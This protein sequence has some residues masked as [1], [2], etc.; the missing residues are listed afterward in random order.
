MALR[1]P[2]AS[3][4]RYSP[5]YFLAALGAGGLTANFFVWLLFWVPHPERPV[6]VF[7]DIFGAW[8]SASTS[9]RLAIGVAV[10]GIILFALTHLILLVWN[11]L[12]YRRYR[13]TEAAR[14]LR[15]G[16]LET[17][18]L[19]LPL[20]VAMAINVGFVLGM[21]FVPGLWSVVEYLFP[22][23]MIAFL[24]VGFWAL[25]LLGDFYGRVLTKGGFDCTRNNSFAQMLPAFALAMVGVGLAAPAAM[26]HT[27]WVAGLSYL[28]SSFF[29]VAAL[30]LGTGK[31]VLGMRAMMESGANPES[32]PTLWL[33]VPIITVL[34]IT[35]LRQDHGA[36]VHLGAHTLP[37]ERFDL[38]VLLFSA[39]IAYLLLGAVVLRRHGYFRRFV[40]GREASSGSWTLIC[41]GVAF[42]VMLH[43]FTNQGLV[44]VGLIERFDLTYWV[45]SGLSILVQFVTIALLMRLAITNFTRRDAA[46]GT[47]EAESM[48]Q[49]A[50]RIR[51]LKQV[52]PN[53]P[54]QLRAR[55]ARDS[56]WLTFT[57]RQILFQPGDPCQGFLLVLKGRLRVEHLQDDPQRPT[58]LYRAGAGESCLLTTTCLLTDSGH[59]QERGIAEGQL[60]VLRLPRD[61]FTTLIADSDHFRQSALGSVSTRIQRLVT[62]I[63]EL[64]LRQ[65]EPV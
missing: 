49:T 10:T 20:T 13:H 34:T 61:R 4:D 25:N 11:L 9:L 38:L 7:E 21:V 14:R 40:F 32:A 45:M 5:L 44:A 37:I 43:F 60:E 39:Q 58:L 48:C 23:A 56:D 19:A 18:L 22:L 17:Q 63:D 2:T 30:L 59:Y 29:A 26:S 35:F 1:M 16:N 53:W 54:E 31:M 3:D 28:L 27:H 65:R 51:Q 55:L 64:L 42:A 41:P 36:Y 57:D 50:A 15:Q 6:P 12:E 46:P 33:G 52:M 8:A 62:V 47:P 24:L